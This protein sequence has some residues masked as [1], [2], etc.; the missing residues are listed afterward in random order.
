[1]PPDGEGLPQQESETVMNHAR[2]IA[3]CSI[4]HLIHIG[5][6]LKSQEVKDMRRERIQPLVEKCLEGLHF[7]TQQS[8]NLLLSVTRL[9]SIIIIF[10]YS[11]M[12]VW[13]ASDLCVHFVPWK[14]NYIHF[15]IKHMQTCP[16]NRKVE[17]GKGRI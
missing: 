15:S 5:E 8:F 11:V 9:V 4:G 7:R 3:S 2:Q 1:M 16:G 14:I 12:C 13:V 17:R 10:L 6:M